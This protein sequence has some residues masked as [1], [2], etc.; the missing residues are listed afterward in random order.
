MHHPRPRERLG[1]ENHIGPLAL[2]LCDQP[3]PEREGLGVRIVD[4]KY[5]HALLDPVLEDALD[6]VPQRRPVRRC[7]VERVDVLVFLGRILGV[8]NA[9]VRPPPEPFRVLLHIGMIGCALQ[10]DIE[11]DL[12]AELPHRGDQVPEIRGLA[13][14]GMNRLVAALFRADR[15][16]AARVVGGRD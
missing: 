13:Q 1:Q 7:E 4:A 5:A 6:L 12:D 3:L 8:L 9:A 14:R 16:G 11:R 10:R 2:D 15:P